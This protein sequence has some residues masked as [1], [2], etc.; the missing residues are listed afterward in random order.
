MFRGNSRRTNVGKAARL[1]SVIPP[2]AV[3]NSLAKLI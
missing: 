3:S 1:E 2:S